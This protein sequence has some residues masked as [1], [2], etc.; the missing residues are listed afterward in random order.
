MAHTPARNGA[1]M[2][3]PFPSKG[4]LPLLHNLAPLRVALRSCGRA[5]RTRAECQPRYSN[6][7]SVIDMNPTVRGRLIANK[8]ASTTS[9]DNTFDPSRVDQSGA[10]GST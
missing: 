10:L 5:S 4:T 2:G 3:I 9:R 8:T 7:S 1:V 6:E